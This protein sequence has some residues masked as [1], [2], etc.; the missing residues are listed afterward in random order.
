MLLWRVALLLLG[1]TAAL[2]C[3]GDDQSDAPR[4]QCE[5]LVD[6]MCG[7]H[8]DC[9]LPTERSRALEDCRF[10]FKLDW[11]CKGVSGVTNAFGDCLTAISQAQC[12]PWGGITQPTECQ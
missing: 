9:L 10:V 7:K 6:A 11:N 5:L 1:V 8:T 3:G 12:E 2:G 4:A